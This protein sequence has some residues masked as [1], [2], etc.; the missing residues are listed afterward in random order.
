MPI[1]RYALLIR[2]PAF[3]FTCHCCHAV[4]IIISLFISYF[5]VTPYMTP[6]FVDFFRREATIFAC[7]FFI[8]L[9]AIVF[10]RFRAFMLIDTPLIIAAAIFSDAELIF[11][12]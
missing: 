6:C 5:D 9:Y 10:S 8:F 11:Q 3:F 7:Y 1:L 12:I 4:V 2:L